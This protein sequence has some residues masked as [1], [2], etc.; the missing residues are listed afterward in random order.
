MEN[1]KVGKILFGVICLGIVFI[2]I[3]GFFM[4]KNL[5]NNSIWTIAY[6]YD[7]GGGNLGAHVKLKYQYHHKTYYCKY[8]GFREKKLW[9][10]LENRYLMRISSDKP[11]LNNID[12]YCKIP[13]SIKSAPPNGWKELPEWAKNK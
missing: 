7:I 4:R 2:F 1:E 13:D 9:K 10:V 6:P 3:H 5:D 8:R 12:N 11:K